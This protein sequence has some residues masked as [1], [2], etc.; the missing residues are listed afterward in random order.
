[1]T[2]SRTA[3]ALCLLLLLAGCGGTI[4]SASQA[5]P[6]PSQ[7]APGPSPTTAAR[8]GAPS[9]SPTLAPSPSAVPA[10]SG[11]ARL[12]LPDN[13]SEVELTEAGLRKTISTLG[14]TNPELVSVVRWLLDTGAYKTYRLWAEGSDGGRTMGNVNIMEMPAQGSSLDALETQLTALFTQMAGISGVKSRHITLPAGE[15]LLFTCDLTM[16]LADGSPFTQ[17]LRSYEVIRDDVAYGVNFSCNPQA[18]K[19]CLRDVEAMI[20]T[21]TIGP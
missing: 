20:Q 15:A 21:L 13:W 8:S 12:T 18:P 2:G 19:V 14:G 9:P 1:M 3:S 16:K 5:A 4:P 7:T 6:E 10:G 17:A 11:S